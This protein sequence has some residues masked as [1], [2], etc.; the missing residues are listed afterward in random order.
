MK[1]QR[2]YRCACYPKSDIVVPELDMRVNYLGRDAFLREFSTQLRWYGF[3]SP[4]QKE[5]IIDRIKAVV[6]SRARELR[7][8]NKSKEE[9]DNRCNIPLDR[10]VYELKTVLSHLGFDEGFVAPLRDRYLTPL[11]KALF[12]AWTGSRLDSHVAFTTFNSPCSKQRLEY[13][14]DN[15]EVSL[16]VCLGRR[17]FE[18]GELYFA[19]MSDCDP[20]LADCP[21]HLYKPKPRWAVLRRGQQMHGSL[22]VTSGERVNLVLWL[23]SSERRNRRCPLCAQPPS[24]VAADGYGDG[25][26]ARY[27]PW[28]NHRRNRSHPSRFRHH[29]SSAI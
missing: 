11:A 28:H 8:A 2:F 21:I 6:T 10:G 27:I 15:S 17:D 3:G 25:F 23:R 14:F 26:T 4:E 29:S 1:R 22:N 9:A 12:P 19:D 20:M 13:R 24:L 5:G 7:D 18:G 16:D